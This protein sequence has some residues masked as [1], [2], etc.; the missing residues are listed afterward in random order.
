MVATTAS[1]ESGVEYYFDCTSNPQY[2]S[3]WQDS[4]IY[5]AT[6]LA[7]GVY[8]FIVRARDKSPD[9][10]TTRDSVEITVDLQPPTPDPM[11]WESE[12]AEVN[13]GG[14]T[15]DYWAEMTAAEATDSSG[16]VE[17]YF[18]CTTQSGF[19]SGWQSSRTYSVK[20]GRSLQN[21]MFRVKARD[22]YGN[23]TAP[24]AALPAH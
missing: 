22:A 5:Q 18:E 24:S 3:G 14:G 2:S 10:N 21:Q 7:K 15:F 13:H 17:Y 12:P 20:I 11:L 19:S 23:E 16:N 9:Q 6:S 4:P 1:D 8:S